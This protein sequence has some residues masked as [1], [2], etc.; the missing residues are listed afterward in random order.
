MVPASKES[1]KPFSRNQ[2]ATQA[3][4]GEAINKFG[5]GKGAV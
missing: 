4:Q 2:P 5:C 1:F 3:N